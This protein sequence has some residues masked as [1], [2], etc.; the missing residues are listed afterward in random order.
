M[1]PLELQNIGSLV[2]QRI[3]RLQELLGHFKFA[4]VEFP[5]EFLDL[6]HRVQLQGFEVRRVENVIKDTGE[7]PLV[8]ELLHRSV[9]LKLGPFDS[10]F[11][12]LVL[13]LSYH[14][15]RFILVWVLGSLFLVPNE[16]EL[17]KAVLDL[18][19][20]VI[21]NETVEVNQSLQE[22]VLLLCQ[23]L[24]LQFSVPLH[25]LFLLGASLRVHLDSWLFIFFLVSFVGDLPVE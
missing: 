17:V 10:L 12:F 25:G 14:V 13:I 5:T 1:L 24:F 19:V 2:I 8:L 23:V 7:T 4:L 18:V 21:Q 9:S 16:E 11:A 22:L 20:F 3:Q 15:W 6:E